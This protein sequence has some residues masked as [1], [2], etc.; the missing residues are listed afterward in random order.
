MMSPNELDRL[1]E[2]YMQFID[3]H[4]DLLNNN[5]YDE[6]YEKLAQDFPA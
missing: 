1:K 3:K 4:G 5:N 6:I 2:Q